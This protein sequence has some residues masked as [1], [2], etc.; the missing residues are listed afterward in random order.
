[1]LPFEILITNSI[2]FSRIGYLSHRSH[3]PIEF[4]VDIVPELDEDEKIA[5]RMNSKYLAVFKDLD[6]KGSRVTLY[7]LQAI[8]E[9]TNRPN[10]AFHFDVSLLSLLNITD[11]QL[12]STWIRLFRLLFHNL[13]TFVLLLS[14]C[15]TMCIT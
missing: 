10:S 9:R 6:G 5:Y 2:I 7:D 11:V 1:M 8:E 3:R 4:F 12:S 14:R 13:L 15:P